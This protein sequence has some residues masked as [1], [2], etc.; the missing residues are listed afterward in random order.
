M[1]HPPAVIRKAKPYVPDCCL[2]HWPTMPVTV[3][4]V[5]NRDYSERRRRIVLEGFGEW[6]AR[7][8]AVSFVEVPRDAE[9]TVQFDLNRRSCWTE[10]QYEGSILKSARIWMGLG[11]PNNRGREL[12][13]P[14]A[15]AL[16]AHEAGHALGV[17]GHSED[18][19]DLMF[20][21]ISRTENETVSD[22]DL[23]TL[24]EAYGE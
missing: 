9:V 20:H 1:P 18:P 22:P 2:K 15:R 16:S 13:D 6:H 11:D 10:T 21:S 12:A 23:A 4:F 14:D 8:P 7:D 3:S 24:E 19:G 5:H 17:I